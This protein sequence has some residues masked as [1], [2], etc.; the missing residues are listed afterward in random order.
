MIQLNHEQTARWLD[1]I[2]AGQE[3]LAPR[4][5]EGIVL[6]RPAAGADEI[7]MQYQRPSLSIKGAFLPPT[8]RLLDIEVH[9]SQVQMRTISPQA[10]RVIFGVRACDAKGMRIL[11]AAFV[12]SAPADPTYA[13]RRRN[14][15]QIGLACEQMGPNCFC[16]TMGVTPNDPSNMD[17]MLYPVSGGYLMEVVSKKGQELLQVHPPEGREVQAVRPEY[18]YKPAFET[19]LPVR[20]SWG[21]HFHEAFWQATAERC[22]S[23]RICAYVC[24]TCR[25]FD[26]R[27]EEAASSNGKKRYERVRCWDSCAG[28]PY[29]RIAGGHNSRPEK[30]QRLRNRFMCKFDYFQ[31]QYGLDTPACTGCGRCIEACPVDI[32]ISEVMNHIMEVSA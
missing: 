18:A 13:Q 30:G 11:D 14:T 8:E 4:E 10:K 16:T 1:D 5:V 19:Q 17:I 12:D 27:D 20:E 22:L 23:C 7:V 25:C 3:L 2:A 21:K 31:A 28:S 24:P 15:T 26:L 9:G 29:R 32:D 6:Y